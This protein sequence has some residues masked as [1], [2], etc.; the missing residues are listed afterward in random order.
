MDKKNAWE[1]YSAAQLQEVMELGE[2][3]RR[4]ISENKTERECAAAGVRMARANGYRSLREIIETKA[5][6]KPQDK[7][8]YVMMDKSLVLFH[9]GDRPLEEGLHILGAHIDSPR[10]DLKQNP[11]YENSEIAYLDTHYYGGIKKYQWVTL[12]LA[13]HGVIVKKDG[14]KVMVN[15]GEKEDDPVF[16]VSDLLVH[17]A[18]DQMQK[19]AA[20]VIEGEDLNVTFGSM[21]LTETE[22]DKVKA[23]VLKLLAERYAIEEEDFISAEIEVVPAGPARDL[24]IDRSMILGYGQDD[25][26]CAYTSLRAMLAM[27]SGR[28]RHA[29]PLLR[30]CAG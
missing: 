30:Q 21:P 14:T 29:V 9:L 11:L 24:G 26:V 4:F 16:C 10:L 12:P 2:E 27:Q 13:L 1:S 22:K 8:Y 15:I 28:D 17:L 6:L 5:T 20:A 3:Y 19:K 23:N 25:R 18:N 7:V